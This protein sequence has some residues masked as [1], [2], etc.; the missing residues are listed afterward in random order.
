VQLSLAKTQLSDVTT[1][2]DNAWEYMNINV[3]RL[4]FSIMRVL[5]YY[6]NE[7]F[8]EFILKNILKSFVFSALLTPNTL[9]TLNKNA[10]LIINFFLFHEKSRLQLKKFK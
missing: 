5:F 4:Y 9:S 6:M 1:T 8:S 7:F 2:V 3:K 10:F